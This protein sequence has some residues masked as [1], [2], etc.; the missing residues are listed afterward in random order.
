MDIEEDCP[1]FFRVFNPA[2]HLV[3]L[4]IGL[5]VDHIATVFLQ[6]EDFLDGGMVPLGRLQRAFGAAL[7]DPL[8]GS[9]K[10][11]VRNRARKG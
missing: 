10:S 6:G 7:A 4:G 3:G 11:V 1:V 5:E 8:A 9:I 2:L